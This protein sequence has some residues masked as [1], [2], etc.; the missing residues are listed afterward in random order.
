MQLQ[1]DELFDGLQGHAFDRLWEATG[2]EV[3]PVLDL[4]DVLLDDQLFA[5]VPEN[6]GLETLDSQVGATCEFLR[7]L[8][9]PQVLLLKRDDLVQVL[10]PSVERHEPVIIV[11]NLCDQLGHE[12]V[13][14]LTCGE[15]ALPC[16]VPGIMQLPPDIRRP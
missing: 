13:P 6:L 1:I 9:E 12:V 8:G 4:D 10:E 11:G 14:P 3:D 5:L 2:E 15:V 16:R 7:G